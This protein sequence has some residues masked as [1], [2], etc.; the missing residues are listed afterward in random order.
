M[1]SDLNILSRKGQLVYEAKIL[2]ESFKFLG[3]DSEDPFS[4]P[5]VIAR[6]IREGILDTPHFKGNPFLCGDVS[7]GLIQGAWDAVDPSTGNP[8]DEE[9]R[10]LKIFNR[11]KRK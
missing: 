5:R 8:I 6:A 4:D 11:I 10:T 9:S 3:E 7:T 1:F 2:L